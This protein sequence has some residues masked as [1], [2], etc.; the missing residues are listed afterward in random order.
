M[1][2]T[3]VCEYPDSGKLAAASAIGTDGAGFRFVGRANTACGYW[4][5]EPDSAD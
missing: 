4:D 5:D 2:T 1:A 3:D